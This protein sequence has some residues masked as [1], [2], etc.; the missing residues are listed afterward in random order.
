VLIWARDL[1]SLPGLDAE[2]AKKEWLAYVRRDL[3]PRINGFELMMAP[4]I[5][6]HLRLGLALQQTGFAFTKNDRLRVFLTN[7]L[8]MQTPS[9]LA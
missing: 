8:E 6:S 7:T 3:L 9:Q 5:V 1:R 2:A 4:Y